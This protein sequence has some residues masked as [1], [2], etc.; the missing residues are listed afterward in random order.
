MRVTIEIGLSGEVRHEVRPEDTALARGSGDVEVLATPTVVRLCEAAAVSALAGQL[1]ADTTSV[2]VRVSMDHLAPTVPGRKVVARASLEAVD[3]R[4]LEF[5]IE[6]MDGAGVIA[7]GL[8][9]RVIVD[10]ASFM[11]GASER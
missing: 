9:T 6:A 5:A 2:G 1:D 10:R 11:K 7:R 3:G 4:R 8:H